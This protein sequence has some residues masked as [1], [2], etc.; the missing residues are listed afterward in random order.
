[1]PICRY[2][3][4]V[5]RG[6]P[7]LLMSTVEEPMRGVVCTGDRQIELMDF[8]DPTSGSQR[9]RR[10]NEGLRDVRRSP[11][12]SPAK[13]G[14]RGDRRAAGQSELG[15]QVV[16]RQPDRVPAALAAG[17][18]M[19]TVSRA[20]GQHHARFHRDPAPDRCG[21]F[22]VRPRNKD[23]VRRH[24]DHPDPRQFLLGARETE[25]V[26]RD[27]RQ[28]RPKLA[29]FGDE[30]AR[31]ALLAQ[32]ASKLSASPNTE[33]TLPGISFHQ[34][35]RQPGSLSYKAGIQSVFRVKIGR[36]LS[37]FGQSAPNCRP[38]IRIIPLRA[39][40]CCLPLG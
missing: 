22:R 27:L 34:P 23:G 33:A 8:P 35:G 29:A 3:T 6:S 21:C 26:E 31:A 20:E 14:R 7:H 2:P 1:L 16:F 37:I 24:G 11:S 40:L 13:I 28:T 38:L 4:V 10:R 5:T 18:R 25:A 15:R 30:E 19:H 17:S 32:A 9:S 39:A 36:A 12:I